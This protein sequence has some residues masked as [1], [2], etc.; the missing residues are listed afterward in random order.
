MPTLDLTNA[1]RWHNLV[2][3]LQVHLCPLTTVLMV[4][5]RG[6]PAVRRSPKR[7]PPKNARSSCHGL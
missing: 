6:D 7:R 5:T 2:S 4:A 1:P 3:G